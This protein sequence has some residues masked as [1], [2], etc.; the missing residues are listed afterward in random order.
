MTTSEESGVWA[1][2]FTGFTTV[3]STIVAVL[4]GITTLK[5]NDVE[6]KLQTIESELRVRESERELIFRL[7]ASVTDTLKAN[8]GRQIRATKNVVSALA[9]AN[10]RDD[11]LAILTAAEGEIYDREQAESGRLPTVSRPTGDQSSVSW[12]E[13][14]IDIFWCSGS[15]AIAQNQADRLQQAIKAD[16]AAGRIRSRILPDARKIE[17]GFGDV[18]GYQVRADA[19]DEGELAMAEEVANFSS[20]YLLQ[21]PDVLPMK[22]ANPTKWYLSVFVCPELQASGNVSDD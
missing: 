19:D 21:R 20:A 11:F 2:R 16:K 9:P 18:F 14:D 22:Q 4:V 5:V 6:S 3:L 1:K 12:G 10:L 8:D 13:W 15:G 17:Q 7:F